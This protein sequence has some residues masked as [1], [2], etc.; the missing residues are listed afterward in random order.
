MAKVAVVGLGAM[1]SRIARRLLDSGHELVVWNRDPARKHDRSGC[2]C[3][4]K[5]S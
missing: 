1:G 3:G 5:P 4:R 2:G